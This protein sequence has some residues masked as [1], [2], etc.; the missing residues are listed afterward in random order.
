MKNRKR[1]C[2]T[3]EQDARGEWWCFRQA[4]HSGPHFFA[5]FRPKGTMTDA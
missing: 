1:R 5:E 2:A 4:Y 3:H